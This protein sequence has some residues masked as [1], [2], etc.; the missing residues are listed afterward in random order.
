MIRR[1]MLPGA[2][3]G[4]ILASVIC[5]P[6][7]SKIHSS[8][9]TVFPGIGIPNTCAIGMTF[10][11]IQA[12]TGDADTHSAADNVWFSRAPWNWWGNGRFVLVPS[13]AAVAW[14][15]KNEP[16]TAVTF[17]TTTNQ[18]PV[19]PK[20]SITNPF[21]G[22]IEPNLSF[23]MGPV[24]RAQVEV[25]FGRAVPVFNETDARRL[26]SNGTAY[27]FTNNASTELAYPQQGITFVLVSN[28]VNRFVVYR[29]VGAIG[30]K[31]ELY[32]PTIAAAVSRI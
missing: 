22:I 13:L 19:V 2:L 10:S 16:V 15:G 24:T 6:S 30:T 4:V 32:T 20:L 9:V 11:Q 5:L 29:K 1:L 18:E 25:V 28:V 3:L 17:Y 21:L 7:G 23:A 31:T 8:S 12:A 14:V 26:L 27:V